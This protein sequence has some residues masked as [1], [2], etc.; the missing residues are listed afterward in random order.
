MNHSAPVNR[1]GFLR[2]AAGRHA[3][4]TLDCGRLYVRYVDSVAAGRLREFAAAVSAEAG[5]ASEIQFV[6][7]Q[8]LARDEFRRALE[9]IL[10][11]RLDTDR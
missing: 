2:R 6:E 10:S 7:R 5:S 4:V 8:W 9:A 11:R 3:R 1:R